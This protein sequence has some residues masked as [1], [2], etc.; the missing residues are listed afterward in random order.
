ME[1]NDPP[2]EERYRKMLGRPERLVEAFLGSRQFERLTRHQRR[3]AEFILDT[4]GEYLAAYEDVPIEDSDGR[5]LEFVS[6]VLYPAK[7]GTEPDH[8]GAVAPVLARFSRFLDDRGHLE[9]QFSRESIEESGKELHRI[10]LSEQSGPPDGFDV[11]H[12]DP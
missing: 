10:G 7:V 4:V 3:E 1:S 2:Y 12:H 11:Y 8:F 5:S 9:D 6:T